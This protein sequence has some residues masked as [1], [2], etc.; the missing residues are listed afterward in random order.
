M[1]EFTYVARNQGGK[2]QRGQMAADSL[3]ALRSL[4]ESQGDRL[5][6]ATAQQP[7]AKL[8][9]FD[10]P[11]D[12]LPPRSITVEVALEQIAVMLESGL[13][14]LQALGTAA[15]QTTSASMRT[16]LQQVSEDIQ[17]GDSLAE[18]MQ[19]HKCFPLIAV[20]LARVG[21]TTGNLDVVLKRAAQQMAARRENISAVRTAVAYPAFVGVAAMGV[22]G[23][24]VVFVIPELEK[25]LS[26]IG[27]RLPVITQSLLDLS[28]WLR[29]NGITVALLIVAT[30]VAMI[31]TYRVPQARV[32]IDRWLLRIP[33]MGKVLRLAGTV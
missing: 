31:L 9:P 12:R 11:L 3:A 28:V 27:R 7:P 20:Q 23:Y 33:V 15:E 30:I 1:P 6:S 14:I 18:A 22:A 26:A 13:G 5:I 21:E 19:R 32:L 17:E 25:F 2:V 16:I 8:I 29:T 10:N 24:L 4:L